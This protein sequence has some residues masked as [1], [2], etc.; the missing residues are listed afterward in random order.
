[1]LENIHEAKL[2]QPITV[3]VESCD[4]LM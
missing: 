1:M 4:I 2:L 3:Y